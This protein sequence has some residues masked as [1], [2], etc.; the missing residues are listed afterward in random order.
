MKIGRDEVAK[1]F[2]DMR[3]A[4]VDAVMERALSI[5]GDN[6]FGDLVTFV[7]QVTYASVLDNYN[8]VPRVKS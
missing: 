8:L 2:N 3:T 4:D 5:L 7:A 6:D 1:V